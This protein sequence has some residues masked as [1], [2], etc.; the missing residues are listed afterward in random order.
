[1]NL[2]ALREHG[3]IGR[4]SMRGPFQL[5][6]GPDNPFGGTPSR[7]GTRVLFYN[8]AW[9]TDLQELNVNTG[10]LSSFHPNTYVTFTRD[11]Q[12]IAFVDDPRGPKGLFCSRP[13]G[14]T[15]RVQLAPAD[16]HPGF[17]RWSPDARWI[18]FGGW[19]PG[20]PPKVYLVSSQGGQPQELLTSATGVRDADWSED[21]KRL[22]VCHDLGL[23]DSGSSELLI[24]DFATRRA[25]KLP[26][27]DNLAG[28]RWS[29]D[30]RYISAT[31]GTEL[32]LWSLKRRGW[33]VIARGRAFGIAVWSPDSHYVYF[34]DLLG[35]GEAVFRYDVRR[36]QVQMVADFSEYLK[37]G[38]SRCAL[39]MELAAD[40]L[41]IIMFNRSFYD[42]YAAAT[43]SRYTKSR[44]LRHHAPQ[45]I[46]QRAELRRIER[47]FAIGPGLVR[48]GMNL[49]YQAV[50]ADR[51]RGA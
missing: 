18:A 32:K 36:R 31:N 40:G 42:L 3:S 41:P 12:R 33:D 46:H 19:G 24:V 30:G 22:V 39:G 44:T 2:W 11:G 8:G 14:T 47:L 20:Q 38:V 7:D 23:N 1:M 6:T 13:D 43:A 29:P 4:R 9:Q 45:I 26:G 35:K 48:A 50:R 15:D 17:P 5:T 25:D 51:Q 49:N 27:S 37:S 21:G 34:Q 16:L 28:T 10:E